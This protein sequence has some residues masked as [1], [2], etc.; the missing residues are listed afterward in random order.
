[1][2]MIRIRVVEKNNAI[3]EIGNNALT[4]LTQAISG[5]ILFVLVLH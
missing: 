3:L 1:M 4:E 2:N 5:G